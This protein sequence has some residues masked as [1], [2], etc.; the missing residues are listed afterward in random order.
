MFIFIHN[1][2]TTQS[3]LLP[4]LPQLRHKP[5][6]KCSHSLHN[7]DTTVLLP[8]PL[9]FTLE[10]QFV[11]WGYNSLQ[12][13]IHSA[14]LCSHSLHKEIHVADS[15]APVPFE[16][17]IQLGPFCSQSL[18]KRDTRGRLSCSHSIRNRDTTWLSHRLR[19]FKT[20]IQ[21]GPSCS[22]SL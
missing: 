1:R 19:P 4:F 21:L 6:S 2:N 17:E 12:I 10:I 20:E 7:R 11:P 16:T 14:P 22:H 3:S 5:G 9:H 18:H 13:E 8:A 15:H